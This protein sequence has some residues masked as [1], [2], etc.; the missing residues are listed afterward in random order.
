MPNGVTISATTS[1]ERMCSIWGVA[2]RCTVSVFWFTV[3]G[4]ISGSIRNSNSTRR[5]C[6]AESASA[7]SWPGTRG[8][9]ARCRRQCRA[10]VMRPAESLICRQAIASTSSLCDNVTE[11]LM[12][13][14]EVFARRAAGTR[15]GRSGKIIY[16][17]PQLRVLERTPSKAP[18]RRP[19][20][21]RRITAQA[22]YLDWAHLDFE[23]GAG[24]Q[25]G[26]ER[27]LRQAYSWLHEVTRADAMQL[28][29]PDLGAD[30]HRDGSKE[31]SA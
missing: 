28:Q 25:D 12:V 27:R 21:I 8:H 3:R 5:S 18:H 13:I 23:S 1:R 31:R 29:D 26:V 4:T 14:D 19:R 17:P 30:L 15:C 20:S 16:P 2:T 6:G 7:P 11:H 24:I 22:P 9:C 10:F